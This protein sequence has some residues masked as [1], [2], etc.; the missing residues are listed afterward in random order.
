MGV[1]NKGSKLYSIFSFKCPRCHEGDLYETPT[2]SYKKPFDMPRK[3]PL[4]GQDYMPEPGFYYG[5]MF[6]GYIFTGWFSIL[7]VIFFHWV[8]GWSTAA[9]FALLIA[10]CVVFFVYFFRLAR[11][12]WINITVKYDPQK[13]RL[14][15]T[16]K[17]GKG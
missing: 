12:I 7:F 6:I 16:E 14:V 4:C 11:A 15:Q 10:V 3:C 8:L 13:V 1:F 17:K 5:A 2:F 9:S